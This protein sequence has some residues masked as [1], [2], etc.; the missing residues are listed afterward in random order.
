MMGT[1]KGGNAMNSNYYYYSSSLIYV[2]QLPPPAL[3][4]I[5]FG[6]LFRFQIEWIIMNN[7][8]GWRAGL[9][10][11]TGTPSRIKFILTP[12]VWLSQLFFVL[13]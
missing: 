13:L 6:R 8:R 7:V 12:F 10:R 9:G 2:P 5:H 1:D 11:E 3:R 4:P